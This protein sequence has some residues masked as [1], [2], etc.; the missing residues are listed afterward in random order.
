MKHSW[1]S[2]PKLAEFGLGVLTL[3]VGRRT[4]RLVLLDNDPQRGSLWVWR[5]AGPIAQMV[6]A[7]A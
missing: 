7:Q 5:G 4:L 1:Q 6:A 2:R 3:H